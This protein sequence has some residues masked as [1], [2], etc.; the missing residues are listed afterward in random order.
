MIHIKS[1][2]KL[3]MPPTS[4]AYNEEGEEE[5]EDEEDEEEEEEEPLRPGKRQRTAPASSKSKCSDKGKGKD[6]GKDKA[7][8]NTPAPLD[9]SAHF[10]ITVRK[11]RGKNKK[12]E[13]PSYVP[14]RPVPSMDAVTLAAETLANGQCE[15]TVV[16]LSNCDC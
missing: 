13:L 11:T 14:P 16:S 4:K 2:Q 12:G 3:I 8:A 1:S 7:Q 9:T 5:K 15:P 10:P 6:K